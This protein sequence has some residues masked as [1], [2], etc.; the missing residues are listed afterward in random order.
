VASLTSVGENGTTPHVGEGCGG[1]KGNYINN[2]KLRLLTVNM[3]FELSLKR[4]Y[5]RLYKGWERA[6][7]EFFSEKLNVVCL[8]SKFV[9]YEQ[10]AATFNKLGFEKI[11]DGGDL[12]LRK[13][14]LDQKTKNRIFVTYHVYLDASKNLV[15]FI[16]NS[17]K[18]DIDRTLMPAVENQVGIYYMYIEPKVFQS[19][20]NTVLESYPTTGIP[21]F[22]AYRKPS[23]KVACKIRPVE[24]RSITYRG[25]DGKETL[26]EFKA[27]YG[28]LPHIIE[29][30]VPGVIRFR[31]DYKGILSFNGGSIE[32]MEQIIEMALSSVLKSKAI[33]EN[34]KLE[35]VSLKSG[36]KTLQL[37]KSNSWSI[38]FSKPIGFDDVG[39]IIELLFKQNKLLVYDYYA[40]RGSLFWTANVLSLDKDGYFAIKSDGKKILV[41]PK[42]DTPFD[43]LLSFYHFFLENVDSEAR[44]ETVK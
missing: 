1:V 4:I 27:L 5:E 17:P 38:I 25:S 21:Y 6:E 14:Y 33:M 41:L 23:F 12:V 11:V 40:E 42:D 19:I 31:I 20:Q 16:T 28:M 8:V 22:T 26:E 29:F 32:Y 24:E 44:I 18:T 10:I 3:A 2:I 35:Y 37:P 39:S 30:D 15:L 36:T 7:G 34:A 43:S 9:S 13:Y